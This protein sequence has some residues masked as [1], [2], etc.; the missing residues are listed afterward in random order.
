MP[1]LF[2]MV[3]MYRAPEARDE[4]HPTDTKHAA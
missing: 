3:F 1:F 2:F 4:E